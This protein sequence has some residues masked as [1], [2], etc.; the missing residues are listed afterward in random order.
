MV[1]GLEVSRGKRRFDAAHRNKNEN[2]MT[3]EELLNIVQQV[4]REQ[5]STI[6]ERL[7]ESKQ[8]V[9][10]TI[11]GKTYTA[12]IR[13][14]TTEECARL[15]SVPDWYQWGDISDTQR[16]T[17]LGNGWN[18]NV[19]KHCFSFLPKFDRPIRVLSLF[20]GMAC[21][22]IALKEL[23]IPLQ[24]Y[25]SSEIDSN[26]I[27]AEKMNFPDMIQVG[28]VT[29]IDVDDLVERYGV[30]DLL[31]G[32]SPCQS[33]SMSGTRKGMA[34][35]EGEEVY[36]LER[37]LELKQCGFSFSGQS[38]LFWEYMR[39]LTELRK[40]NPNIYFFLEN[41]E[42]LQK[43]ESCLSHAIGVRG[44]H[45]NAALVSAQNRK[46]IYWSNFRTKVAEEQTLFSFDDDPFSLPRLETD[47]PQ[48]TDR[49]EVISDV[50]DDNVDKRF[51]LRDALVGDLLDKT[52]TEKL[53][54]YTKMPQIK[55]A[56]IF[57]WLV[58]HGGYPYD[59]F[60]LAHLCYNAEKRRL[61]EA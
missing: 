7:P 29:D 52:D 55:P 48:P 33:F 24:Y 39:I 11:N 30:P 37:Y 14:L 13:R 36:T 53:K 45:I 43:W 6:K 51:Y 9:D 15:Q 17:M 3:N 31:I 60:G 20:D 57:D 47:I 50:L 35:E 27:R 10:V 2:T 56:D 44:V 58:R 38:Y 1:H 32:G 34:T 23:D 46:R 4:K 21:G 8:G 16:Y 22:A 59:S 40:H 49:G 5:L 54:D 26:A 19:I 18:V 12:F 28:S 42:M 25:I 61:D 41:V